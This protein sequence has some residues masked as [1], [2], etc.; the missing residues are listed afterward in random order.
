MIR[1]LK[2]RFVLLASVSLFVLLSLVVAGMNLIN[3][4]SVVRDADELLALLSENRGSFPAPG[5]KDGRLP[6]HLSPEVPY[7]SRYFSVE[8]SADGTVLKSDTSRVTSIDRGTAAV[9]AETVMQAGAERGFAN[10][11]RFLRTEEGAA[12][13]ITFLDRG[14][15][16]DAFERFLA[17]SILMALVG[18]SLVVLVI[19]FLSGRILRPIAESYEKQKRFITDAGHEIKTPLTVIRANADLLE[20]EHGEN[21]SIGEI[22]AQTNRLTE[23]TNDLTLLARME[24]SEHRLQKIEFPISEVVGDAAA[25]FTALAEVQKKVLDLRIAPMLS[26]TG[27]ARSVERLVGLL[28]D[29]ALKYSPAGSTVSL[30]LAGHPHAIV[31]TVTNE[32]VTPL[33]GVSPDRV[34]DRFYRAD[35]SR[36]SETGGHGIGLSVAK[37]I[38]TAHGGKI[39]AACPESHRFT[40]T[41]I[42][43][44]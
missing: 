19:F 41:A 21:E 23:L 28:L 44:R 2:F 34:F 30:T 37:A 36:N 12:V 40:V 22:R 4:R 27:N 14:R 9:Y 35:P 38:V 33:D 1:K 3:Y 42:F 24:E 18:F 29:N 25:A 16:L 11:Y 26:F 8:L 5:D 15:Q 31:L 10:Q 20:I 17:A 39:R 7:E 13:R 43:P 6:P 32:T